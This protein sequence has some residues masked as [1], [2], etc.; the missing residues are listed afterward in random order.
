M[1]EFCVLNFEEGWERWK[2]LH[3][4]VELE[5]VRRQTGFSFTIPGKVQTTDPPFAHELKRTREETDPL[6]VRCLEL[7]S[8]PERLEAIEVMLAREGREG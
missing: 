1:T 5:K 3:P 2:S 4:G 6:G 8:G 7:L